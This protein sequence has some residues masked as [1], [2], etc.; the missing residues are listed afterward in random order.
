MLTEAKGHLSLSVR[1]TARTP[2]H[3][4]KT[5]EKAARQTTLSFALRIQPLPAT[6]RRITSGRKTR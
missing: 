6:A 1:V 3:E 5:R 2:R 4:K